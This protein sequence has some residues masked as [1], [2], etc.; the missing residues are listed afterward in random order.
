VAN[1]SITA[2]VVDMAGATALTGLRGLE[3]YTR[4]RAGN[5]IAEGER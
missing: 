2:K 4:V 1:E 3:R 5:G